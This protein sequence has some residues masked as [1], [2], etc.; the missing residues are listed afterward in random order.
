MCDC[1]PF[2]ASILA[3][4]G[5]NLSAGVERALVGRVRPDVDRQAFGDHPD[6]PQLHHPVRVH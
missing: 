4:D 5:Q 1:S 6:V 2:D 3:G